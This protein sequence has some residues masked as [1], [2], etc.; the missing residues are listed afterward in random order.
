MGIYEQNNNNKNTDQT[1]T[2][3][4]TMLYERKSNKWV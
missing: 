4:F 1:D 2:L 3:D